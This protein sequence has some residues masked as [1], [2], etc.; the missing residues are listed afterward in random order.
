[1]NDLTVSHGLTPKENAL[2]CSYV[3]NG[4]KKSRAARDAGMSLDAFNDPRI[5]SAIS[6]LCSSIYEDTRLSVVGVMD[7]LAEIVNAKPSDFYDIKDGRRVLKSDID[8]DKLDAVKS[9][10]VNKDGLIDIELHDFHKSVEY[11]GRL[12]QWFKEEHTINVNVSPQESGEVL[13]NET[14]AKQAEF[15]IEYLRR[16]KDDGEYA[17]NR[18]GSNVIGFDGQD[19]DD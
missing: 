15:M 8:S 6:Y 16:E 11:L 1:M 19:G 2:V 12:G 9:I 17:G 14:L 10:T 13:D 18:V 4:F 5:Q 3:K 7:R